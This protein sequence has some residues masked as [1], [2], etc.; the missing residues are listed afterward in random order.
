MIFKRIFDAKFTQLLVFLLLLL[1]FR[2]F[3]GNFIYAA[4]WHVAFIGVLLGSIFN[5]KHP[6]RVQ[7]WAMGLAIPTLLFTWGAV[8]FPDTPM[9]VLSELFIFLFLL[10][11]ASSILYT[12]VIEAKVTMETLRGAICTYL[13]IGIAFSFAFELAELI[14]PGSFHLNFPMKEHI[15]L[16]QMMYFSFVTLIAI[17]YGDIV[18]TQDL[19]QTLAIVEG[20]IGQ[21]YFGILVARLVAV[22]SINYVQSQRKKSK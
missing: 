6:K 13:L 18:P 1:V 12:V 17:G 20:V 9:N 3:Q 8:F 21:F 5:C 4:V 7:H 15:F 10:V 14:V 19:S 16:S 22:Y 2:P 11:C